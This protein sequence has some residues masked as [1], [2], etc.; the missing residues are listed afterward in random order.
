[1]NKWRKFLACPAAHC[2][3]IANNLICQLAQTML[4]FLMLHWMHRLGPF[5]MCVSFA[6]VNHKHH[7]YL[8]IILYVIG[9]HGLWVFNGA[10]CFVSMWY[11]YTVRTHSRV[12]AQSGPNQSE[13]EKKSGHLPQILLCSRSKCM[14][15]VHD[16][17]CIQEES[18]N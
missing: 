1:M 15:L 17:L 9:N 13:L 14:W 18:C 10:R 3:A 12:F 8:Y 6:T 7:N 16:E 11:P 2:D 4:I 5:L